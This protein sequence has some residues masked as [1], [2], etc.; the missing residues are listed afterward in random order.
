MEVEFF[1]GEV[2]AEGEGEVRGGFVV[3]GDGGSD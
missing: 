1:G 2:G 3:G